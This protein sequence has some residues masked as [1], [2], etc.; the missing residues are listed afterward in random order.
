MTWQKTAEKLKRAYKRSILRDEFLLAHKA[1]KKAK[2]DNTLRLD[3]P[4]NQS[5]VVFDVGGYHGDF[6]AQIQDKFG[7]KVFI[8]EPSQAFFTRCQDRF[9]DNTMVHIFPYGLAD[10]TQ[11]VLLSND[12]DGSSVFLEQGEG[13]EKISLHDVTDVLEELSVNTIDLMKINIEGGEF[14]LLQK[15]IES[16]WISRIRHC[17]IQFHNFVPNARAMRQTI[18]TELAKTH[19]ENWNYPFIW[20]SW[21][22]RDSLSDE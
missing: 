19:D 1:W 5:S 12:D 6:A 15:L 2:G 14:P 9:A 21:S 10:T 13:S 11:D 22:L 16:G 17:Q 20:E 7:C 4:L 18:R 8:F 3:Y